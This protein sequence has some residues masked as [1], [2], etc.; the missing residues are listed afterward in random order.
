MPLLEWECP[1]CGANNSDDIRHAEMST[2]KCFACN[3]ECEVYFEVDICVT[4]IKVV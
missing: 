4:D 1:D 3:A 2:C